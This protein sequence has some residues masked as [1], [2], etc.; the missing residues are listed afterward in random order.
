MPRYGTE[1]IRNIATGGHSSCGKTT[2]AD[3][4][5]FA[6]G[7]VKKQGSVDD[8]SSIFDY[9]KDEKDRKITL[10]LAIAHA[11]YAGRHI[12][13][14]DTPGYPDFI[15]ETISASTAVETFMICVAANVGIG[16]N[17]RN[18]FQ[19]AES[20]GLG[21]AVVVT[22]MDAENADWK[23][24]LEGIQSAFGMRCI[25]YNVPVGEGASFEGV[26]SVLTEEEGAEYKDAMLE[27]L[28]EGDES[29]VEKYLEGEEIADEEIA[30]AAPLAI[31]QGTAIPVFFT[32]GVSG[33]GVKELLDAIA[34]LFPGPA[35]INRTFY[36][37]GGDTEEEVALSEDAPFTARVFKI[38]SDPYVG[39]I[40]FFRVYS[41]KIPANAPVATFR[42]GKH[43]KNPGFFKPQGKEQAEIDAAVAGD[44]LGVA[45]VDTLSIDDTLLQEGTKI[46]A[47]PIKFPIP[48][49]SLAIEPKTRTD[50]Q[51]ISGALQKLAQEDPTFKAERNTQ[52]KELVISGISDFHLNVMLGALKSRFEVEVISHIP[53]IPYKETITGAA[54]GHY[55]HK[56]QTGGRGQ[57]AEVYL[58]VEP[59]DR[60][61]GFD[62]VDEITGG[63]I[64][65]Q[66]L[67]AVEKGIKE[68]LA[69]GVISGN[70][71]EDVRVRVYDGKHHD[72]D[73][74][75]AAFKIAGGRAFREAF[76]KARPVLLEPIVSISVTVPTE[77]M[78]AIT[79]S[80]PT[81]RGRIQG[82]DSVGSLQV[83][84]AQVPLAEVIAYSTELKQITGGEGSFTMEFSH[85][86]VVPS[87]VAAPII[88]AARKPGVEEED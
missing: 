37:A 85:Y 71:V 7:A 31:A 59:V 52:T 42:E 76:T 73:S 6:A 84:N 15:G 13:I 79:G 88:E 18:V 72:V 2:L 16:L 66:F 49:V 56:K 40:A 21:R 27:A 36:G 23:K 9:E 82:I 69:T 28:I 38:N 20:S 29:L 11:D 80:L 24:T 60:G 3:A 47:A 33:I 25:P 68:A 5:L 87:H 64:P 53:K 22:K 19:L 12:N 51:R 34:N 44:I 8:G 43:L 35:A 81:K 67:P 65:G 48:M 41:G 70:L 57:F 39:K 86:D 58:K 50:E 4:L 61:E 45:K 75:E 54:S 30:A 14:L 17:T 83:V 77:F 26:K 46:K 32:S 10:D 78:G 62:F 1:N 63:N 74:S 55:R